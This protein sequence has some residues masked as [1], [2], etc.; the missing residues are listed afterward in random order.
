MTAPS[1]PHARAV[2]A[3]SVLVFVGLQLTL[4]AVLDFARPELRDPE[5]GLKLQRL[6]QRLAEAPGR[7]LVIV[8]GSSR[9]AEG[10]RP[11]ALPAGACPEGQPV[12]FNFALM[13]SGPVM[14]L[15]CLRRLL[16][17]G[18]RPDLV[19][20]ECW[21]PAWHG[22]EE[23]RIR[24]QRLSCL[25]LGLLMRYS[26]R[27]VHLWLQWLPERLAPWFSSRFVVLRHCTPL[28]VTGTPPALIHWDTL[29]GSGWGP[30]PGKADPAEQRRRFRDASAYFAGVLNQFQHAA[31]ADRALGEVLEVCRSRHIPAALLYMPEAPSFQ[32]C[33]PPALRAVTDA[34]LEQLSRAHGVPLVNA[35][36]WLADED[37]ADGCHLLSRG[38]TAFSERFGRQVLPTLLSGMRRDGE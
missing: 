26:A 38:A 32:N 13:G 15:V 20:V 16:A 3:W 19:L 24:I 8:L 6:R 23:D 37:F 29:D 7:P 28:W 31:S 4:N 22:E 35:R 33:Y 25:D 17:D 10:F 21:P 9:A 14:E 5:Y 30:S 18:I 11:A 12:V 1:R 36:G 2:M 27:P 34:Y